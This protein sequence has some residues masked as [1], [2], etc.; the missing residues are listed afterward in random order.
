[1]LEIVIGGVRPNLTQEAEF[2]FDDYY[3]RMYNIQENGSFKMSKEEIDYLNSNAVQKDQGWIESKIDTNSNLKNLPRLKQEKLYFLETSKNKFKIANF[4]P[5]K[6]LIVGGSKTSADIF[7]DK[8]KNN[9]EISRWVVD[10]RKKV[11]SKK[12]KFKFGD[13][14]VDSIK[15]GAN[16]ID[17]YDIIRST[18]N[19]EIVTN[20]LDKKE[21][22]SIDKNTDR[23]EILA[24]C[25]GK[26]SAVDIYEW[27][28]KKTA[29]YRI[30]NNIVKLSNLYIKKV[31]KKD[32][33]ASELSQK[34]KNHEFN[35]V[36]FLIDTKEAG[37]S[38]QDIY[39][40]SIDND[41]IKCLGKCIL[42]DGNN[43]SSIGSGFLGDGGIIYFN[44]EN[45]TAC[46]K[47]FGHCSDIMDKNGKL[48]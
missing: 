44:T 7:V 39:T 32:L 18:H 47:R 6:V 5:V 45:N 43:Y 9:S 36:F 15:C 35:A 1:M 20:K 26:G 13:L 30:F 25:G 17:D 37:E 28:V 40:Q 16:G 19:Q 22:E 11:T 29:C 24:V 14:F 21:I 41:E 38:A 10:D 23:E 31:D 12:I 2:Y 42:I 48:I 27:D 33:N 34:M 4:P 8:I 46:L 3:A